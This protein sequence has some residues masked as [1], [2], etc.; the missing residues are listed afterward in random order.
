MLPPEFGYFLAETRR[1]EPALTESVS[2]LSY[3]GELRE[4]VSSGHLDGV[5][6]GV[7]LEPVEH[8]G[9]TTSSVEEA[10]RVVALV[11]SASGV[12]WTTMSAHRTTLTEADIIVVCPY[13]AHGAVV[14]ATLDAAGLGGTQVG[15]VDK[16]QGQEAIMSIVSL[17][18]SFPADI[19]R[20]S[21]S[22]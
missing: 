18:A 1:M 12:R 11:R 2:R 9:N 19:P 6:A 16:F 3:D 22:C 14:R 13:N 8:V 21:N 15:T 4:G 17:A 20:G 5:D 7:H 10:E